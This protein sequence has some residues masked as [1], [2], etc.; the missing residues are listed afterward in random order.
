[1][2]VVGAGGVGD[3]AVAAASPASWQVGREHGALQGEG[4]AQTED[5]EIDKDGLVYRNCKQ[6]HVNDLCFRI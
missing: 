2:A 4:G 3:G 6:G 1:M 5:A